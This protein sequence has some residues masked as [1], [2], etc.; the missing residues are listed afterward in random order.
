MNTKDL[1]AYKAQQIREDAQRVV[2]PGFVLLPAK[3]KVSDDVEKFYGDDLYDLMWEVG[4][5]I[6]EKKGKYYQ[7]FDVLYNIGGNINNYKD[8]EYEGVLSNKGLLKILEEGIQYIKRFYVLAKIIVKNAEDEIKIIINRRPLPTPNASTTTVTNTPQT[9]VSANTPQTP[10]SA[11][12]PQTPV[13]LDNSPTPLKT[14]TPSASSNRYIKNKFPPELDFAEPRYYRYSLKFELDFDRCCYIIRNRKRISKKDKLF[15]DW[16]IQV[17]GQNIDTLK[18]HGEKVLQAVKDNKKNAQDDE[19]TVPPVPIDFTVTVSSTPRVTP[20]NIVAPRPSSSVS[21]LT[22][23]GGGISPANITGDDGILGILQNIEKLTSSIL[24]VIKSQSLIT[25]KQIRKSRI[26]EEEKKRREQEKLLESSTKKV[27]GAFMKMMAPISGILDKIINFIVFTF[28]GRAFTSLMKW[29]MDPKNK[30]KVHSLTRF[31]KDWWP[32]ILGAFVL[33][34]TSFGSFIRS[35]I[36]LS[37]RLSKYIATIGIPGLLKLLGNFAKGS[38][39]AALIAGA[40]VG[41]G[42]VVD[43]LINKD[44]N[45]DNPK[46]PTPPKPQ[47]LQSGGKVLPINIFKQAPPT[48]HH[49]DDIAFKGGGAISE[50]SGLNIIGAGSDTN[51]IAA[52]PGEIVMNKAAADKYG[53]FLLALNAEAGGPNANQPKFV[54]NI[55][56]TKDGGVVGGKSILPTKVN[57]GAPK[58]GIP[59]YNS[60]LAITAL[61]DDKPQGRADV[62][63]SIYNRLYAVNKYGENFLQ[64]KNSIKGLIVASKQYEPTFGNMRDWSNITDRKSAA[65]AIM[66]STKGRKYNWDMKMAMS[67]INDTEKA[68]KSAQLQKNSQN[69]VQ[70]RTFFLGTSQIKNMKPNLGD[71]VRDDKSNFFSHWTTRGSSYEKERGTLAAPIPGMIQPTKAKSNAPTPRPRS[72]Q[73]S[74]VNLPPLY[75]NLGTQKSGVG[76]GNEIPNFSATSSDGKAKEITTGIYGLVPI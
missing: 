1:I 14:D 54:N 48:V 60:L 61:E 46:Q 26:S 55:S 51:L 35:T 72:G 37:L 41:T 59:D 74:F 45:K 68:I 33:F 63:Q 57:I 38:A 12:T 16:A 71:V 66:N 6:S 5:L 42:L 75:S 39:K 15:V 67:Q 32:A 70:G 44:E 27:G 13:T 43:K 17:S 7:A 31:F 47:K 52:Q 3:I 21:R 4:Q 8:K 50:D 64:S 56:L 29:V 25:K 36:G 34:G 19:I 28:L 40:V 49:I 20:R 2:P 30:E 53:N 9:P 23:G 65:V 73:V 18:A 24:D 76:G 10:A 58:I 11:N 62:A 69:H 22:S